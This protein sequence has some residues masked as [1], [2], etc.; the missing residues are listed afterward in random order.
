VGL[1]Y[2]LQS[3]QVI[4]ANKDPRLYLVNESG[5]VKK[6]AHMSVES[7]THVPTDTHMTINNIEGVDEI[8]ASHRKFHEAHLD[9]KV[10]H[11]E[12]NSCD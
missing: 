6:E 1:G 12:I 2:K 8:G 7:C 10:L 9:I 4:V 5:I 11:N 3:I